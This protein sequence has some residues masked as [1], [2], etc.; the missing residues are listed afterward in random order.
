[1][2]AQ[3][4]LAF[5]RSVAASQLQTIKTLTLG[6]E[7]YGLTETTPIVRHL[8]AQDYETGGFEVTPEQRIDAAL[9]SVLKA[10]GSALRHYTMPKTLADMREAMRKVMSDAYIKGSND[11]IERLNSAAPIGVRWND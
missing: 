5:L 6:C 2:D 4:E 11:A 9:D 8:A 10:S 7:K 3:E 1:M